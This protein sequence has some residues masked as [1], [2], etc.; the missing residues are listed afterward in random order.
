[1]PLCASLSAA[2][3]FCWCRC[4]PSQGAPQN[5]GRLESL[6]VTPP[7]SRVPDCVSNTWRLASLSSSAPKRARSPGRPLA[8]GPRASAGTTSSPPVRPR[9]RHLAASD[10]APVGALTERG[11]HAPQPNSETPG[12]AHR[13]QGEALQRAHLWQDAAMLRLCRRLPACAGCACPASFRDPARLSASLAAPRRAVGCSRSSLQRGPFI[14]SL[15]SV[16][17]T[18]SLQDP[19]TLLPLQGTQGVFCLGSYLANRAEVRKP[20]RTLDFSAFRVARFPPR[21]TIAFHPL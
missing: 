6:V 15:P 7:A 5:Q 3:S 4:S 8:L 1:M 2:G 13:R 10:A 21:L 11:G 16:L 9:E 12:K 18:C 19:L 17:G 20:A 14:L